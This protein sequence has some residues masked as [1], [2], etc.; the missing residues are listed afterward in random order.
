MTCWCSSPGHRAPTRT[1]V[2]RRRARTGSPTTSSGESIQPGRTTLGRGVHCA[3][4]R[5]A[6]RRA[7]RN[8]RSA[9]SAVVRCLESLAGSPRLRQLA[10]L[11]VA[12]R[13]RDVTESADRSSQI[14]VC[15]GHGLVDVRRKV[16]VVVAGPS[17]RRN[18]CW[19]VLRG[20]RDPGASL[21]PTVAIGTLL[22]RLSNHPRMVLRARSH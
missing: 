16:S 5:P 7:C 6:D 21:S 10:L 2:S 14:A 4:G 13:R 1:S 19:I 18:G 9:S 22:K 12:S 15:E 17:P 20:T 3:A 11:L 8:R